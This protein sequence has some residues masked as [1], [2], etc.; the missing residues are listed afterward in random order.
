MTVTAMGCGLGVMLVT[1]SAVGS[2]DAFHPRGTTPSPRIF[3]RSARASQRQPGLRSG[4][5]P[6]SPI[7]RAASR[8]GRGGRDVMRSS[9]KARAQMRCDRSRPPAGPRPPSGPFTRRRRREADQ[10]HGLGALDL[11]EGFDPPPRW[12]DRVLAP[13]EHP[14]TVMGRVGRRPARNMDKTQSPRAEHP[15]PLRR[16]EGAAG[17]ERVIDAASNV[18]VWGR[19]STADGKRCV[20]LRAVLLS[21]NAPSA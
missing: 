11:C 2:N 9:R 6:P 20:V 13:G 3:E 17:R 14:A 7:G 19:A 5:H 8:T 18:R 1:C 15:P 10:Q 12:C 16:R 4:R 21:E